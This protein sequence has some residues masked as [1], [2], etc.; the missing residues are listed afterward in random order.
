VRDISFVTGPHSLKKSIEKA[1][2]K[3][4]TKNI[5]KELKKES[6]RIEVMP[7]Q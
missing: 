6:S 5:P 4:I 7:I 2:V 1:I 3:V